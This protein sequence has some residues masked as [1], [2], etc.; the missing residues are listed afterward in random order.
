M[1]KNLL[2]S[3]FLVFLITVGLDAYG[4]NQIIT[5]PEPS[6]RQFTVP[7]GVTSLTVEVWGAGGKGGSRLTSGE[8]GGGGGGAYSRSVIAVTPGQ[9]IDYYVGFGSLSEL[10]GEDTWFINNTTLMAKG[11]NSVINDVFTAHL[12]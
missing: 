10:P 12:Q 2:T 11:G 9:I 5:T 3:L 1:T 7:A 4:Q 8:G 6:I